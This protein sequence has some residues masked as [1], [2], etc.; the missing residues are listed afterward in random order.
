MTIDDLP[1]IYISKNHLWVKVDL[2]A[3]F[4]TDWASRFPVMMRHIHTPLHNYRDYNFMY[5]Y[6]YGDII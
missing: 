1:L 2:C 5:V 3:K 6:V 4:G